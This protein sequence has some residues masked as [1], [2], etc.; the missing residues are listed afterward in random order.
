MIAATSNPLVCVVDASVWVSAFVSS[1]INH[2]TSL[3][4]LRAQTSGAHSVVDPALL[5][6]EVVGA[7]A[8]RTGD[9]AF[10]RNVLTNLR[11]LPGLRLVELSEGGAAREATSAITL[12][13]RGP[14]AVYVALAE[15]L[16][17]PLVTWDQE[18]M[19]RASAVILARSP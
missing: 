1:D 14:D 18:Q 3:A 15:R 6:P 5:L 9:P 8:R 17:I 2:I 12:G 10:A 11:R 19:T 13:L 16:G 4:W 7:L